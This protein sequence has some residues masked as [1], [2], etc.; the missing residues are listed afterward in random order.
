MLHI[1]TDQNRH[2]YKRQLVEMHRQRYELFVRTKG[3]NLTVRDGGEYDE[4]DDERAIYLLSLDEAGSCFGS[5]RVRP[6]DDFSMVID[7][8]PHHIAGD[9]QALRKDP[10]LWEMARWINIG[11]D[12]AAGV[13]T[14]IGLI[15]YLLGRGATQCL[16]LP[17]VAMMTYA[18]RTG[19][20]VRALG[21]PQPYPEGGVAVAVSLPITADEV[22]YLRD[23]NGRKDCFLMEIDADAPWAG[24]ALS[25]IE[26][27]FA[28]VAATLT[29][30]ADVARRADEILRRRL[31]IGE[32]A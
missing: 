18:I 22:A 29:D 8:M 23:L 19:W 7:R 28:E 20:R 2:L 3:W 24:M 30:P 13:E 17:D 26:A 12:P 11:G 31:E 5:I 25:V 15:E 10:G 21:G 16:A 9:A 1:C 32:V 4:G 14:R 27:V 6:A